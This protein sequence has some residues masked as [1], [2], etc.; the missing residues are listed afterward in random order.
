MNYYDEIKTELINNEIKYFVSSLIDTEKWCVE[1][2]WKG[3]YWMKDGAFSPR[4]GILTKNNEMFLSTNNRFV[5]FYPRDLLRSENVFKPL[6]TDVFFPMGEEQAHGKDVLKNGILTL[7]YGHSTFGVRFSA[8]DFERGNG[9]RFEYR[10][11]G[12][13][14]DGWMA[15]EQPMVQWTDLPTGNY[16]LFVRYAADGRTWSEENMC[17]A[18]RVLPPWW[19]TTWAWI[20][21]VIFAAL[22]GGLIWRWM[23]NKRKRELM[24]QRLSW[25]S[26]MKE[27]NAKARIEFFTNVAHEIRTPVSLIRASVE[28]GIDNN[29]R[30][31]LERN[32]ERLGQLV[33][34]LLEFRSV[35]SDMHNIV[36]QEVDVARI[37]RLTVNS[38][39]PIIRKRKLQILNEIEDNNFDSLANSF[40]FNKSNLI[41]DMIFI[42]GRSK[43][44]EKRLGEGESMVLLAQSLIGFEGSISFRQVK[45]KNGLNKY[46]NS[47][48]DIYVDGPGL[49]FFE[50]FERLV[51]IINKSK[52]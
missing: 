35:E 12:N 46:V 13:N 27:E 24:Q 26:K 4:T 37:I 7:K 22:A 10:L 48:N 30:G 16:E 45:D 20:L 5:P 51:P 9:G 14:S 15:A 28:Q 41:N 32:V 19:F 11:K 38:F 31:F 44:L 49:I 34:N 52:K 29:N 25:E 40:L 23:K 6:V 1:G 50:P 21:Y 17:L 2:V 3:I 42:S 36:C 43:I 47:L 8:L 33:D 18:I 39:E